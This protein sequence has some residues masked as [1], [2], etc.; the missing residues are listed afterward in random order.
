VVRMD[1]SFDYSQ[2]AARCGLARLLLKLPACQRDAL[3]TAAHQ[4]SCLDEMLGAYDEA[5]MTLERYRKK[6][7]VEFALI[8]EY[9]ILCV[10]LESDVMRE[11]FGSPH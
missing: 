5:C 7:S 6:G 11:V 9:E 3:R 4:Q 10:E 1:D 8:E 2:W